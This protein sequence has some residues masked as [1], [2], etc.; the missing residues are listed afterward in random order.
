MECSLNTKAH[1][2]AQGM[3]GELCV[4]KATLP[5]YQERECLELEEEFLLTGEFP[6]FIK[7]AKKYGFVRRAS[8]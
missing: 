7:K 2:A 3:I 6:A 8:K 5:F 1:D 4:L